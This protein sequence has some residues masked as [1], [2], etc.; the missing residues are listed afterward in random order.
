MNRLEIIHYRKLKNITFNFTQNINV[1]SGTNGT[2]KTSLLHIIG[3]SFQEPSQ[4]DMVDKNCLKIIKNINHIYAPKL[5]NL[6]RGDKNYND[7]AYET[8]GNLYMVEY[9]ED[10]KISFRRHNSKTDI[11]EDK[12]KHRFRLAPPYKRDSNEKLRKCPVIYLGLTRLVPLGEFNHDEDIQ[13]IS[14]SMPDNYKLEVNKLYNDIT[15]I[16][17]TEQKSQKMGSIKRRND[18][19]TD[20]SGVDSNTISAG[21]DNVLVLLT[22]L[23]SLKYYYENIDSQRDIESILLIDELDA[24]LHPSTQNMIFNKILEYS[25]KYK[26]Q[27]VFTTHSFSLIEYT[28]NKKQNLIYL[29][30]NNQQVSLLPDPKLITIKMHL[31]NKTRPEVYVDKKIPV[32]SEDEEARIFINII[33]DKYERDN[34]EFTFIRKSFHLVEAKLGCGNIKSIFEDTFLSKSI[35]QGI[36]IVDGD[37]PNLAYKYVNQSKQSPNKNNNIIVLPTNDKLSPEELAMKHAKDL[38]D[39]D[40][41]DFWNNEEVQHYGFTTEYFRINIL[42]EIGRIV[43]T[44]ES[45]KSNGDTTC[46]LKRDLLKK[47]FNGEHKIFFKFVLKNWVNSPKNQGVIN[48]FIN[49]LNIMFKR[50]YKFHGLDHRLWDIKDSQ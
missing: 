1:I 18:F 23:V 17:I 25:Q 35:I 3:N 37:S 30:L 4:K 8:K 47:L 45:K 34:Q 29:H 50:V 12:L 2:C 26:I 43:E 31:Y 22:A 13:L 46:G 24:T 49:D 36:G 38:Y 14:K 7:P 5:E 28:E 32:F 44:I 42:P 9:L 40:I 21:E 39:S 20:K 41:G 19:T 27:V 15:G 33:F 48:S 6:T 11:E 10:Y 16:N